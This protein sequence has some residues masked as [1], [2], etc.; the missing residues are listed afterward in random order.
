M[1]TTS[2]RQSTRT[3]GEARR[4]GPAFAAALLMLHA[5]F[6]LV[7]PAPLP[8]Q[9]TDSARATIAIMNFTS[10]A[11]IRKDEYAALSDG[12]P[13]ILRT[14]LAMSPALQVVEREQ[15]QSVL[16]ELKLQR[17]EQV[18]QSTAVKVGRLLGAQYL[19]FGG[20]VIDPRN[21]MQLTTRVVSVETGRVEFVSSVTG[22]GSDVFE[23]AAELSRKLVAGLKL[24][25]AQGEART[26]DAGARSLDALVLYSRA[27]G[28]KERGNK[29][30][31]VELARQALKLYPDFREARTMLSS[32]GGG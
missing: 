19:L 18:D 27:I 3:A 20:F 16:A 5:L 2:I 13:L 24:A 30:S 29:A 31:A 25:P 11:M 10:A 8:A 7:A 32:L 17:S 26:G 23:L 15:L 14:E 21:T 4:A 9:A 22:K 28:E 1:S 12:I 6:G